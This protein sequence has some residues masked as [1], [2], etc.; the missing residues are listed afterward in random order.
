MPTY[1][2][3]LLEIVKR[4]RA[5]GNSWPATKRE[6]ARWALENNLWK[7]HASAILDQFSRELGRA[8]R[9]EYFIDPQ[10]RSV[11]ANHVVPIKKEG[12]E[13]EFLWGD[14]R[15]RQRDFMET[16]LQHRRGLILR[17]CRH[18]KI[19][20]DSFNENYNDGNPVQMSF[21]F[22][23]DV[24]ELELANLAKLN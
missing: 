15:D 17:D 5:A 3:Q 18:L 22:T 10:G 13:Q 8:M 1:N 11:R 19:D 24:Q 23:L 14:M 20:L 12:G 9:E 6:I 21:D 4:Y 16:S 7:P 2:E